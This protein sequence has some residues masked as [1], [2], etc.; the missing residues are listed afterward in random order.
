MEEKTRVD[1]REVRDTVQMIIDQLI[2]YDRDTRTRIFR[3]AETF[4]GI[5]VTRRSRLLPD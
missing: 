5:D 2:D 4:F 1:D 3:T